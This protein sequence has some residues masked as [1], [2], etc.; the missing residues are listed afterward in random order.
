LIIAISGLHGTGKTTIAKKI[1]EIFNLKHYSTGI[2][3]REMAKEKNLTLEELSKLAEEDPSI[4][5]ELDNKIKQYAEKGNCVL[6]NQLSP[7]LLGDIIDYCILLKC[8]KDV[9]IHRM[10]ER[11]SEN[12]E[13]KRD[14]TE[15]RE[16]SEQKRF[17]EYYGI[18]V[19]DT[20]QIMATFDLILDTTYIDIEGAINIITTAIKEFFRSK[21]NLI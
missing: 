21:N 8:A 20:N 11:D 7:Y 16:L 19:L 13:K 17:I 15:L 18:D 14:E 2:M 6:D 10:M 3:F 5:F 1:A 9:R 4:D 12:F